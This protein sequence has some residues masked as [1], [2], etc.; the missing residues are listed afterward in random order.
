MEQFPGASAQNKNLISDTAFY[1]NFHF[2][3]FL[4]S[5]GSM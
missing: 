1:D 2:T 3:G 4:V 5:V